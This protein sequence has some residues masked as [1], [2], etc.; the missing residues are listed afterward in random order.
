MVRRARVRASSM[1]DPAMRSAYPIGYPLT[2]RARQCVPHVFPSRSPGYHSCRLTCGSAGRRRDCKSLYAGSIPAAASITTTGWN[3]W[4]RPA[5]GVP[6]RGEVAPLVGSHGGIRTIAGV[7]G[8]W[9]R[10]VGRPRLV[11]VCAAV[12]AASLV[13]GGAVVVDG[14]RDLRGAYL[15][16]E[17]GGDGIGF[18]WV[19]MRLVMGGLV[20]L[21]GVGALLTAAVAADGRRRT[22]LR[23]VAW[24]ALL[25]LSGCAAVAL[26]V[27]LQS[28]CI[29]PCG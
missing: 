1:S 20:T 23:G 4:S 2:S 12:G 16:R 18:A 14:M 17:S 7:T 3:T 10:R 28:G 27:S 21:A 22:A 24:S 19:A 15:H 6:E 11:G 13:L 5:S 29:G 9:E 26:W 8:A 25:A